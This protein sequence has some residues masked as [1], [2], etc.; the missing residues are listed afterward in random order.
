MQ[1][2]IQNDTNSDLPIVEMQ[3][4]Q[5]LPCIGQAP[6]TTYPS[7]EVCSD[8]SIAG[9]SASVQMTQDT[10]SQDPRYT[11][12]DSIAS[13]TFLSWNP[14]APTG[15][16]FVD[17]GLPWTLSFRHEIS[18]TPDCPQTRQSVVNLTSKVNSISTTQLV[19]MIV[20]ICVSIFNL[21]S[22]CCI[23]QAWQKGF[24]AAEPLILRQDKCNI[25]A[26]LIGIIPNI[27]AI[28]ISFSVKSFFLSM[29]S[30]NCSDATT[31][32]TFTYIAGQIVSIAG[33]NV[34]KFV[35]MT[36]FL[37]YRIHDLRKSMAA[38]KK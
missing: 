28:A 25:C 14:S 9:A 12:L 37:I 34:A 35:I 4:R 20:A 33:L 3:I 2:F 7:T 38:A 1:L 31:T 13:A 21:L 5:G 22:A 17:N 26:D 16:G 8:T 27:V 23:Y 19:L 10:A 24:A 30:A 32:Q 15:D 11:S 29:Q 18:W 6:Q 36:L